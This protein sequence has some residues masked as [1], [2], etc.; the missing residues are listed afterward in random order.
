MATTAFHKTQQ[1]T[2]QIIYDH[3]K[4]CSVLH[5]LIAMVL[6]VLFNM[7]CD[8]TCQSEIVTYWRDFGNP[9]AAQ[10]LHLEL[11]VADA[12][13]ARMTRRTF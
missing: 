8:S 1:Y 5:A 10:Q 3:T 11:V 13:H 12:F 9:H 6:V 2:E 4:P 7:R